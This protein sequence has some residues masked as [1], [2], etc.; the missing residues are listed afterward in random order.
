MSRIN[1]ILDDIEEKIE[2]IQ[3]ALSFQPGRLMSG[4]ASSVL[5][6]GKASS[7]MSGSKPQSAMSSGN[8][9]TNNLFQNKPFNNINFVN[10]KHQNIIP[11]NCDSSWFERCFGF[12]ETTDYTYNQLKFKYFFKIGK[13]LK[14]GEYDVGNFKLWDSPD[15]LKINRYSSGNPT[16]FN[17]IGDIKNIHRVEFN[18][19]ATIQVASQLNCLEM[20]NPQKAPKNGISIYVD[21]PTQGP[22]CALQTPAGI[23]YRNYLIPISDETYGQTCYNQLNMAY[24]LLQ[25][26]AINIK[27]FTY[28]YINGYLFINSENLKKINIFL[29]EPKKYEFAINL[30]KTASH[31]NMSVIEST[32]HINHVLCSGLPINYAKKLYSYNKDDWDLLSEVFLKAFYRNTLLIALNNNKI[33]GDKPCYLTQVGGG[34]FGMDNK[35][36]AD[37]IKYAF[38]Y[39]N[40]RNY[41]LN[42]YIVHYRYIHDAY[43]CFLSIS[44]IVSP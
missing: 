1:E 11:T 8:T 24:E 38:N 15:L 39:I 30:I 3:R 22:I 28:Q 20:I 36:I 4:K 42:I 13:Y 44:S 23:A 29:K 18:N 41:K 9:K 31:T 37:A 21:D 40:D 43:N 10:N 27:G 5:S 33:Y 2:K 35:I 17:M 25:Y 12:K 19:N 26:F 34:E 14:I 32:N 16:I 7:S 6:S